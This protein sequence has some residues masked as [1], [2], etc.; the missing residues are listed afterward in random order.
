MNISKKIKFFFS[1]LSL[2]SLLF[3]FTKS[4][5]EIEYLNYSTFNF[6]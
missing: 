4:V 6:N 2:T 3:I 5:Q 1:F